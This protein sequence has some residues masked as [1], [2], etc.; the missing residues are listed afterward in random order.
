MTDTILTRITALL[1]SPAQDSHATAA[2]ILRAI[3]SDKTKAAKSHTITGLLRKLD[4]SQQD[5]ILS[6]VEALVPGGGEQDSMV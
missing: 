2:S 5:T 4:E 6:A 3:C 1:S